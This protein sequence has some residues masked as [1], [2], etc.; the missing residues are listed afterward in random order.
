MSDRKIRITAGGVSVTAR[1]HDTPTADRIWAALPIKGTA[2]TWG[3]EVYF[4]IPVKAAIEPGA[5]DA[6]SVG[7][8]AYWPPGSAFC[9]FFGMTPASSGGIIR[10]ASPVN[11]FGAIEEDAAVLKKVKPLDRVLVEKA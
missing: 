11:V 7:D 10:A 1:L 5:D 4:S 8:I 6:V 2:N 3:D 9:M